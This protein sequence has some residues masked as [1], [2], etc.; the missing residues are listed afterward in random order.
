MHQVC[1]YV[2]MCEV[3]VCIYKHICMDVVSLPMCVEARGCW[4]NVF[5]HP[6]QLYFLRQCLTVN[7]ELLVWLDG[8]GKPGIHPPL[9]CSAG[10]HRHTLMHLAFTRTL[11][12]QTQVPICATSTIHTEPSLSLCL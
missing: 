3:Y 2:C 12:I 7:L 9:P 8:L 5:L 1:M 4:Q 10:C 6:F 11:E